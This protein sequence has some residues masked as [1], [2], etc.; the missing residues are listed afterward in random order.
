M[1][2]GESGHFAANV[3][4]IQRGSTDIHN[5]QGVQIVQILQHTEA[6]R[7][8]LWQYAD[9]THGKALTPLNGHRALHVRFFPL[10]VGHIRL[11]V[12]IQ[13]L[14]QRQRHH[15][16]NRLR[17]NARLHQGMVDSDDI[18]ITVLIACFRGAHGIRAQLV[19][20]VLF[21][22]NFIVGGSRHR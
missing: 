19:K 1:R 13:V 8:R 2:L 9:F 12:F 6:C 7:D 14:A 10:D 5:Q 21:P 15:N 11:I 16:I 17:F 3:R 18:H 22:V 20:A 4:D